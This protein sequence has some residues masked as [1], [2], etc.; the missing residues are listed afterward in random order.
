MGNSLETN[1]L[2]DK[3][4]IIEAALKRSDLK[5][6]RY[7]TVFVYIAA[8]LASKLRS[9]LCF[10]IDTSSAKYRASLGN[11]FKNWQR[12]KLINEAFLN[13]ETETE[14]TVTI[15]YENNDKA[16]EQQGCLI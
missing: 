1:N 3:F 15:V 11:D 4:L 6:L 2:R 9:L 5:L 12:M 14:Q 16:I 10:C 13:F 8:T 7:D